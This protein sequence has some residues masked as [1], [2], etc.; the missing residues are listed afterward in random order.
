MTS[1]SSYFNVIS[2]VQETAIDRLPYSL[3]KNQAP[4][5]CMFLWRR[6]RCQTEPRGSLRSIR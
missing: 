3:P 1:L 6:E 5:R 2:R 4:L